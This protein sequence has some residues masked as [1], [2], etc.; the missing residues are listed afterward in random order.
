[1][2][3]KKKVI[4]NFKTKYAKI[5]IYKTKNINITNSVLANF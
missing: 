2:L 1:L 4:E 5:V 3:N